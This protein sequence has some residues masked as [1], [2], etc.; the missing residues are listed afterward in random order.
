[1]NGPVEGEAAVT[2]EK[3]LDDRWS[4]RAFLPDQVPD[5]VIARMFAMAQR[6]ASWCNTQPW[7]VHLTKGE[8]T[9]RFAESL[10]EHVR[11]R[12]PAVSDL[13]MPGEYHG[14]HRERRREAGYALYAGLGISRDDLE[15]RE[16]QYLRNYAF[17]GAPHV[18]VVT[19]GRD[20]GV[21]GAVDCGA[22]VTNLLN[23]ATSLGVATIPQAAIARYA[24]HVRGHLG[25]PEDRLVVCAVSFGYADTAHPVNAFRTTRANAADVVVVLDR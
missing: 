20:Q 19:T 16:A 3:L 22:Y 15:A 24:D 21:Y 25:V 11:S 5:D 6:T 10:T 12:P 4:C 17:F 7:Q 23:A 1:M 9:R 13:P 8:A 18:A 2:F 14:V